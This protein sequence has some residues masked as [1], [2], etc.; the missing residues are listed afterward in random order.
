MKGV[1][2]SH[3]YLDPTGEAAEGKVNLNSPTPAIQP[4]SCNDG[5]SVMSLKK[6]E[7]LIE[8]R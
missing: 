1:Q 7:T 5:E 4:K 3:Q 2:F 6:G 8:Q